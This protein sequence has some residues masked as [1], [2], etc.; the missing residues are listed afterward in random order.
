LKSSLSSSYPS[1][2]AV[3]DEAWQQLK[4]N[5]AYEQN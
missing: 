3:N 1:A 5:A 2:Q 4:E